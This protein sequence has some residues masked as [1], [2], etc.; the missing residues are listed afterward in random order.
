M[1]FADTRKYFRDRMT[2]LGHKEWTD[3][4][5]FE[6]IPETIQNRAFHIESNSMSGNVQNQTVLDASADVTVRLFLLG[7][8]NPAEAIDSAIVFGDEAVCDIV[9]PKNANTQSG[10]QSVDFEEMQVLPRDE[11]NDNSVI[12]EMKFRVKL[13]IDT[14][15]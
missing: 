1:S 13:F 10:F 4:F 6:N 3:A 14:V 15:V 8:R 5:N 12:L 9:N 7:F 11:S 2:G